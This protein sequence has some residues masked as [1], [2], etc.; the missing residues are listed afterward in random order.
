MFRIIRHIPYILACYLH[1]LIRIRIQLISLMRIRILP[2]IWC[3]SIR[4]RIRNTEL[5][6]TLPV[7][8]M[9]FLFYRYESGCLTLCRRIKMTR[10]LVLMS[11]LGLALGQYSYRQ[12]RASSFLLQ[13]TN[14]HANNTFSK[15]RVSLFYCDISWMQCCGSGM[16]ISDSDLNF[17]IPDP[18][19]KGSRIWI[20]I[21]PS[22]IQ[23]EKH[24]RYGSRI[25]IKEFK[26]FWPKKLFLMI[27]DVH[28]GSGVRFFFLSRNPD[29]GVKKAPEPDLRHCLN[30]ELGCPKIYDQTSVPDPEHFGTDPDP[31][32]SVYESGAKT[33]EWDCRMEYVK[34]DI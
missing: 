17:S 26:F 30:V 15:V 9:S 29:P 19:S 3:G 25:P 6:W 7:T 21:F 13:V 28:P 10:L 34:G 22:R 14:N 2:S 20:R 23:G 31:R 11:L 5:L 33:V 4:I 18:G 16:F 12:D 24:P 27:C 1:K 8:Y 32:M